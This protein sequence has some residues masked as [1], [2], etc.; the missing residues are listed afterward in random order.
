[1]ITIDEQILELKSRCDIL[2]YISQYTELLPRGDE[3]WGLSPLKEERTPSFSVTPSLQSFY[4]FSSG[5]GGDIIDFIKAYH[6]CGFEKAIRILSDYVGDIKPEEQRVRLSSVQIAKKYLPRRNRTKEEII[7]IL[8]DDYM[9]RYEK[10]DE[11]LSAWKSEGIS[12]E[13]LDF[14]NVR[15]DAFSNRIV[16]PIRNTKSKIINI[17]GRT[18]NENYKE[19]GQRK[20]T[21]FFPLGALNT[22]YGLSENIEAIKKSREII[23]FEGAKSVMLARTWNIFNTGAVLTSHLNPNQVK[24]LAALGCRV[25]FALDK[26]VN[27]KQDDNIRRLKRYVSVDYLFDSDNLLNEKEAPVDRGLEVF[28]NLYDWRQSFG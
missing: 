10:N 6:G 24:I 12:D 13:V 2:D 5:K 17:S 1:V 7:S 15:Y 23:L 19:L 18:L 16:F 27:I 14:F 3:Y 26:G 21:Y 25:V 28:K 22:V 8:P 4:D 11:K 20:Y 9:E